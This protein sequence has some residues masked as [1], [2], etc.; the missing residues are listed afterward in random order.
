[1]AQY[2]TR[3][4]SPAGASTYDTPPG[5]PVQFL[6]AR[7]TSTGPQ[8]WIFAP[9]AGAIYVTLFFPLGGGAAFIEG[10]DEGPSD[11]NAGASAPENINPANP[12]SRTLAHF[13]HF[14]PL[15]DTVTDITRIKVEGCSAVRVNVIGGTVDVTVRC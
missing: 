11:V 4:P 7:Y 2:L 9:D 3:T 1:M 10:T 12:V 5:R 14:Y 13:Q 15:T 8:E 6:E